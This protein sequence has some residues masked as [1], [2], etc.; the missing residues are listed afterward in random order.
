MLHSATMQGVSVRLFK[1]VVVTVVTLALVVAA[2]L[3]QG[4]FGSWTDTVT[5]SQQ[6]SAGTFDLAKVDAT[7]GGEPIA[8]PFDR[9]VP[10]DVSYFYVGLQNSGSA[11]S[12]GS[13]AVSNTNVATTDSFTADGQVSLASGEAS[14]A[15]TGSVGV[16][17][18]YCDGVWSAGTA[19]VCDGVW[20]PVGEPRLLS[21]FASAQTLPAG[22]VSRL[23]A[24]DSVVGLRVRLSACA[25]AGLPVDSGCVA[26][27]PIDV[28]GA[29][30]ETTWTFTASAV[31]RTPVTDR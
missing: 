20:V 8:A 11:T 30:V 3:A 4:V 25:G 28:M 19:D 15:V 5:A 7:G 12:I 14:S 9:F 23:S 10:G 29:S 31:G 2:L 17:L 6:V 13:L 24:Q 18:D 22:V 16:N 27:V 26:V 21:V 1:S